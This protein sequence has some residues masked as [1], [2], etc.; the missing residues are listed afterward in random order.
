MIQIASVKI[1]INQNPV[2]EADG[3]L[4]YIEYRFGITATVDKTD[5]SCLLCGA[6][7][8]VASAQ[9]VITSILEASKKSEGRKTSQQP[10]GDLNI[11]SVFKSEDTN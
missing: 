2:L 6:Y 9:N 5:N 8:D 7:K 11:N 1:D 3:F 4:G 10:E